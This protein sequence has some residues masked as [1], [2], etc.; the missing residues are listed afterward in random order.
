MEQDW[1]KNE[2]DDGELYVVTEQGMFGDLG[3]EDPNL[4]KAK[5]TKKEKEEKKK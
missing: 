5:I 2:Q 4:R 3:L 1:E